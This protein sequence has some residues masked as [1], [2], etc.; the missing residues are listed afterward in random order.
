VLAD[1][2]LASGEIVDRGIAADVVVL[3]SCASADP[4]DRDELGPLANAFL[5]AGSSAVV[6]TQWSVEDVIARRFVEGFYAAGGAR[7]P[8]RAVAAAQRRLLDERVPVAAWSMFVVV[9]HMNEG[10]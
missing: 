10:D 6:A 3:A 2:L 9:G 1:G 4:L 8:I 5:A 7:S